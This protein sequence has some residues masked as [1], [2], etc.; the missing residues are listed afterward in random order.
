MQKLK[1]LLAMVIAGVMVVAMTTIAASAQSVEP[2][3]SISARAVPV[4]GISPLSDYS[5]TTTLTS[6]SSSGYATSTASKNAYM[7][8]AKCDVNNN[9]QSVLTS[10]WT[11]QNNTSKATSGTVKA[12]TKVCTYTAYGESQETATSVLYG[13]EISKSYS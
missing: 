13:S 4:R 1:K 12:T 6:S 3:Q 9:G 7:V 2:M 5:A 11:T 8:K 10:G